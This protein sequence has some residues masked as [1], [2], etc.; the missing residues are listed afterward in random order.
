MF[1]EQGARD[2][3]LMGGNLGQKEMRVKETTRGSLTDSTGTPFLFPVTSATR[4]KQTVG[5]DSVN[6][7]KVTI[8]IYVWAKHG[9][10]RDRV[11]LLL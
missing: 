11:E 5:Q 6:I 3:I 7:P 1:K 10:L 2:P 8:G 4:K 9:S